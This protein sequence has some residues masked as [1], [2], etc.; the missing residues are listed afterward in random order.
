MKYNSYDEFFSSY[1]P[2]APRSTALEKTPMEKSRRSM[3]KGQRESL[4][5]KMREFLSS[6]VKT[7]D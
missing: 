5:L 4:K 2:D 1:Y 6:S 3:T 7:V